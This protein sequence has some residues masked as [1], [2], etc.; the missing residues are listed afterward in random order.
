MKKDFNYWYYLVAFIDILGQ[1]EAFQGIND[2]PKN[3]DEK[4]KLIR[5]HSHT[6]LFVE[7][8]RGGFDDYFN[9]YTEIKESEFKVPEE[10]KEQ[11]DEMRKSI[12]KHARFSD[13]LQFFVPLENK[14][15]HSPCANGVFGIL[16]ACGG[17]LLWSLARGKPFRAGID[18]GIATELSSGEV[19]GPGFFNAYTL[20][21]KIAQYPRIVIGNHLIN[22]LVNL[23]HK[24][25]QLP[26]QTKEDVELCNIIADSCL[27]MIGQDLDGQY[28]LDYL[29]DKFFEIFTKHLSNEE[30]GL[31]SKV[32][33]LAFDF[34]E[35]EYN[36]QK[37]NRDQKLAFRYFML[38]SYFKSKNTTLTQST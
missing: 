1:K 33:K 30:K 34:V 5:A 23:S 18:V 11:F 25:P 13:C 19:Y 35:S 29:G 3:E 27:K 38:Y 10:K 21:S 28:I 17:M 15:Y 2:L 31:N 4:E 20:E 8:L 14:K 37:E 36:K 22:Y 24:N 12:L 6:A 9:A 7:E 16:G 26:N 32:F